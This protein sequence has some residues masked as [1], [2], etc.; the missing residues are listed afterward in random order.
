MGAFFVNF[1]VKTRSR[2]SVMT[3]LRNL[4]D[5]RAYVSSSRG[6]W[7][8]VYEE[9]TSSQDDEEIARLGRELSS[10]LE[11]PVIGFL[12]HDSDVLRYWLFEGGQLRD[13]FDSLPDYFQPT[14][15][16]TRKRLQGKPEV[17]RKYSK[18]GTTPE[19][20]QSHLRQGGAGFEL[21]ESRLEGLAALLGIDSDRVTLDFQDF[22]RGEL[23]PQDVEAK[24]VAAPGAE[25]YGESPE[26][27]ED[28]LARQHFV[29][30]CRERMHELWDKD[31]QGAL[32]QAVAANLPEEVRTLLAAGA[33]VNAPGADINWMTPLLTAIQYYNLEMMELLI[34][35][36]ADVNS[37]TGFAPPLYDAVW[38]DFIDGARR[39]LKA[40]ADVNCH[41]PHGTTPLMVAASQVAS[42]S[43]VELL[44]QAGADVRAVNDFG[45]TALSAT[46]GIAAATLTVGTP[47]FHIVGREGS[48]S[49]PRIH[50]AAL[51][52]IQLLQ[53]T[54][55]T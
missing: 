12:V 52:I 10:H 20:L 40:G 45:E 35:L 18:R 17:L 26:E 42:R 54:E 48:R 34:Q 9:R 8:S 21:A 43:M 37:I 2:K 53:G 16:D 14:T 44:L 30:E 24:L 1:H 47:I 15:E 5:T 27:R 31:P 55:S 25:T 13:E 36:G 19:S 38:R 29:R 51:E 33:D 32:I 22:E 4:I 7:V 23:S 39:L 11:A 28:S 3:V 49:Y 6:G 50:A 41:G 46:E